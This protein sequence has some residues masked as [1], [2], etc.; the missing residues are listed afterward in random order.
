MTTKTAIIAGLSIAILSFLFAAAVGAYRL[1]QTT[2]PWEA[3]AAVALCIGFF[4]LT[5]LVFHLI[6]RAD[7]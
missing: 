6:D 1:L 5:P 2:D 7:A 4:A 3:F